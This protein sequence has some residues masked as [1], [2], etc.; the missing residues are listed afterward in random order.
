[1]VDWL[2]RIIL[3]YQYPKNEQLCLLLDSGSFHK[4]ESVKKLLEEN[5]IKLFILP[6]GTTS[7]IQPL[8]VCINKPFKDQMR[9]KYSEW[10]RDHGSKEENSGKTGDLKAPRLELL[11][12]WAL[13]C[14]NSMSTDSF[15]ASIFLISFKSLSFFVFFFDFIDSRT[16]AN[17]LLLADLL[18]EEFSIE[19]LCFSLLSENYFLG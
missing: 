11:Q 12:R 16:A 4:L 10:F 5:S 13:E 15:I 9:L 18:S 6:P 3:N 1:M 19:N 2:N 8:D 17:I 7:L 14:W